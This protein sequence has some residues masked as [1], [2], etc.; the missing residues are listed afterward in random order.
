MGGL[1]YKDFVSVNGNKKIKF[2]WILAILTIIYIVLRIAFPGTADMQGFMFENAEGQMVN[3][4]DTYFA[5]ILGIFLVACVALINNWVAK[6]IESDDKNKIKSYIS[7]MPLSK[8]AYI[9][10]KYIF[11][12]ISAY[13][14]LSL[15][16]ILGITCMAFCREGYMVE[17]TQLII[18]FIP[19]FI[20]IALLSAA[21][22]LPLFILMGKEKA[23]LVK[24]A[25]WMVIAFV[26][27]GF[28]MFGNLSWLSEHID[29]MKILSWC[30]NHKTEL[31][32][33]SACSPIITLGIYYASYR[34]TC[35]FDRR[36]KKR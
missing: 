20:F 36:E 19:I 28:V 33:F 2:T 24:I 6:I 29:A 8:N 32:I 18:R 14:F 16:Y 7:A 30:Q 11:I 15:T 26:A 1:L 27:I 9:A 21:I 13:V 23:M 34:I 12:G 25:I 31:M 4:V 10:S 5:M 17:L 35:H 22:E 3:T